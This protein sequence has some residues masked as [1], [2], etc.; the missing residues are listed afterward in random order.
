M[1]DV[2]CRKCGEPVSKKEKECPNCGIK[3]PSVTKTQACLI[4]LLIVIAFVV[5]LSLIGNPDSGNKDQGASTEQ[6][7][8]DKKT[9][10]YQ[11]PDYIPFKYIDV[12]EKRDIKATVDALVELQDGKLP[13]KKQLKAT[14]RHIVS[15]HEAKNNFINFYLPEMDYNG[16]AYAVYSYY[17]DEDKSNITIYDMNLP[18]EYKKTP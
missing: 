11:D 2:K 15:L 14:G 4:P 13:Q 1:A 7:G 12:K 3:N 10:G 8:E 9:T 5:F 16:G 17:R 6:K 18:D